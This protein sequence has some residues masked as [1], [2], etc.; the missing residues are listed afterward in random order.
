MSVIYQTTIIEVGSS[1]ND[2]LLD[3]M[4]ITFKQGAPADIVEFCFIHSHSED[5]GEL[6]VGSTLQLG[7]QDYP[8]T[9]VGEV[10]TQNLRELGHITIR[11]DGAPDAEF[12]GCI[13]VNGSTP[14]H[15][16]VGTELK[17]IK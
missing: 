1:A 6:T 15:I 17:I 9:A 13:H 14:K 11:F 4:M 3:D 5:C 10:A 16:A 8:I 7:N 2:A 12:P